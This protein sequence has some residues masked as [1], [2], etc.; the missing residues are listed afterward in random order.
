M[1]A[2]CSRFHERVP[3]ATG[4]FTGTIP[5]QNAG[6]KVQF[7]VQAQDTLGATSTFPAAGPNSRAIIPWADGQAGSGPA[8]NL[9]LV[10]LASDITTLHDV[11]NVMSNDTIGATVIYRERQ[12]DYDAGVW[13]KGSE[14]GRAPGY[15]RRHSI[16][17]S[18]PTGP[19]SAR[20]SASR[21]DSLGRGRRIRPEGK[22]S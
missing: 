4:V 20:T 21:S 18:R 15:S 3:T 16:C 14:R 17:A 1:A 7:Y 11:T 8:Q 22:C 9:R 5:A 19:F 10:M 12:I 13:L 6:A 2:V